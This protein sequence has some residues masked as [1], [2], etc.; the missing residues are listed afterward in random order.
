MRELEPED[1]EQAS[2]IIYREIYPDSDEEK[3]KDWLKANNNSYS[4][5]FV[6]TV[7]EIV[8]AISW[9]IEDVDTNKC[10]LEIGFLAIYRKYQKQGFGRQLIFESL[11]QVKKI[12]PFPLSFV[13]VMADDKESQKFYQKVLHPYKVTKEPH[14]RIRFFAKVP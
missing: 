7:G 9:E 12:L 5:W 8:G 11:E 10:S 14:G 2:E 6:I 3:I 13:I 1:W 4:R